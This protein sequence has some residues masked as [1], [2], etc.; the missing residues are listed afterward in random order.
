MQ[1]RSRVPTN[2]NIGDVK[3]FV[4]PFLG[5]TATFLDL[6]SVLPPSPMY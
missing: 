3:N 6:L 1:T 4:A 2:N 5:G